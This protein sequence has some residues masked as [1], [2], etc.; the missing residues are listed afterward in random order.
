[1]YALSMNKE[2]IAKIKYEKT[3]EKQP[4]EGLRQGVI[5][6]K[7]GDRYQGGIK[8]NLALGKGKLVLNDMSFFQGKILFYSKNI[9]I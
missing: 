8:Q 1:M 3:K 2:Y 4:K 5:Y 9:Y 7:N 6:F